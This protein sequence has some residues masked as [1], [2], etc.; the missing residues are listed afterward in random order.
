[1]NLHD[2][3][4]RMPQ[5]IPW[6]EGE[7]IPWHEP[8]FSARM[9]QEHLT[10][11]HDAASRRAEIIDQHVSWIHEHV[12]QKQPGNILDLGCGP[13]LYA[14]RLAALG[15][16]C[17]GIDFGPASIKYAKSQDSKSEYIQ[18]DIRQAD[19]GTG[20]DLVMLI[21]GEFNVFKP[22][23]TQL[24]LQ[25]AYAVLKPG[26]QLLLEPHTFDAVQTIGETPTS[27]STHQSGL[28]SDQP[29]VVLKENFWAAEQ[30]VATERY[31]IIDAATAAVTRHVIHIQAYDKADY[32]ALL[33]DNG[34]TDVSFYPS[35]AGEVAIKPELLACVARK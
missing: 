29:H 19:F 17:T 13:G 10:Q 5:P 32:Q 22:A 18:A 21:F 33:A 4:N 14:S 12:L 2:L 34:F 16:A 23:D 8:G 27:W 15:H 1:M 24:I 7:K 26:G 30:R 31:F 3:I 20:R 9:L 11:T 25:K 6:S 28:F 35:L